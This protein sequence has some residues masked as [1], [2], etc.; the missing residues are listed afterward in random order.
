MTSRGRWR[1]GE[2]W[3][4]WQSLLQRLTHSVSVI[5]GHNARTHEDKYLSPPILGRA[6]RSLQCLICLEANSSQTGTHKHTLTHTQ[7][8]PDWLLFPQRRPRPSPLLEQEPVSPVYGAWRWPVLQVDPISQYRNVRFIHWNY[9][10]CPYFCF[11]CY[12]A[13]LWAQIRNSVIQVWMEPSSGSAPDLIPDAAGGQALWSLVTNR[14]GQRARGCPRAR[15][16]PVTITAR[17]R[18]PENSKL[19]KPVTDLVQ[20][21]TSFLHNN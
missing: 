8:Q 12:S 7:K 2:K 16:K 17:E 6:L 20:R 11:I 9:L 10:C 14:P 3:N 1:L 15:R 21:E 13:K 18:E 4:K 5:F 19:N